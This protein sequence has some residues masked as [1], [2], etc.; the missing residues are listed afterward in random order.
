METASMNKYNKIAKT[1]YEIYPLL[2][3]RYSP[4][5]FKDK[6]LSVKELHQLFEAVRWAASSNN[7]QPWRFIQTKKGTK[8]Y[9]NLVHCL[10][11]FNQK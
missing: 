10:S 2:S 7:V 5:I 11:E 6:Q 4:R 8:A 1:D 9:A 3:Q